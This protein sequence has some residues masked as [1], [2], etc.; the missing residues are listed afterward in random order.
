MFFFFFCWRFTQKKIG[1]LLSCFN[2]KPFV[3]TIYAQNCLFKPLVF[4]KYQIFS[5]F[6]IVKM[7]ANYEE[8]CRVG[9]FEADFQ[10]VP[11]VP[12]F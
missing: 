6:P 3:V 10:Q 2:T 9:N 1:E 11:L 7:N 4:K 8:I 5:L 12:F